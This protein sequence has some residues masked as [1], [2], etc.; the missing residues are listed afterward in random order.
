[1]KKMK[2]GMLFGIVSFLVFFLSL[3]M[4]VSAQSAAYNFG[5]TQQSSVI[6]VE[7]GKTATTK[8]FFYNIWGNRMTHATLAVAEKPEGWQV[9]IEPP[10][11]NVTL[12]VTGIIIDVQENLY[13]IPCQLDETWCPTSNLTSREGVEYISG[14]NIDGKIPAKYAVITV[15]APANAPL[16]TEYPLKI[17]AIANWYGEA[18]TIALSQAR[19]FSY[20]LKTVTNQY[21][22]EIVV[23][24]EK[25]SAIEWLVSNWTYIAI[26]L[27]LLAIIFL[28][29]KTTARKKG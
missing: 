29:K 21:S 8:I 9:E 18:G 19:D 20:T 28:I 6:L 27:L 5:T 16:W 1:M 15:T 7:P 17:T 4:F 10:L 23:A 26:A 12:N 3:T 11:K 13:T 2:K 25:P 22:E 24:K 14:S